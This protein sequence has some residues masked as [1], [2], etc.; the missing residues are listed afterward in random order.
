VVYE[1]GSHLLVQMKS[2]RAANGMWE[3]PRAALR[4]AGIE[5]PEIDFENGGW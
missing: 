3:V 4:R 1:R 2:F 5:G